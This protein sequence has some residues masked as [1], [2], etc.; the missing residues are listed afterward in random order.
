VA[1]DQIPRHQ[2]GE[3]PRR[4]AEDRLVELQLQ[5]VVTTG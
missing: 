1:D 3:L 5:R 4:G 2:A